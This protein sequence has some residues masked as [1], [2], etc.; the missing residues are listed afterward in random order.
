MYVSCNVW[1]QLSVVVA[2][3]FLH[4]WRIKQLNNDLSGKCGKKFI[5]WLKKKA[6]ICIK[7]RFFGQHLYYLHGMHFRKTSEWQINRIFRLRRPNFAEV[8]KMCGEKIAGLEGNWTPDLSHAKRA[9]YHYTTS[10]SCWWGWF[11]SWLENINFKS[12]MESGKKLK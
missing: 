2:K 5:Q 6:K 7:E 12:S 3:K 9:W 1:P 4:C 10:P 8:Q 11:N